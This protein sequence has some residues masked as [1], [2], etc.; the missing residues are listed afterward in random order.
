MQFPVY[1]HVINLAVIL[2]VRR[3]P[4]VLMKVS[5]REHFALNQLIFD[6]VESTILTQL[7]LLS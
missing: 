7:P 2:P 4:G 5:M 6:V 1:Q 3:R